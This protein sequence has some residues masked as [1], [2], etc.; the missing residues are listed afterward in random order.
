MEDLMELHLDLRDY[1]LNDEEP[2]LEDEMIAAWSEP[3]GQPDN[4]CPASPSRAF[5]R[6]ALLS[7]K[8][9]P[10]PSGPDF[11][12]FPTPLPKGVSLLTRMAGRI[13][14]PQDPATSFFSFSPG[15][16]ALAAMSPAGE[17]TPA[18]V[19]SLFQEVFQ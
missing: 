12:F 14:G 8:P 7:N 16:T 15:S 17:A 11:S 1:A 13:N 9:L 18:P 5:S 4:E 10:L 19:G 6:A 2:D 3:V